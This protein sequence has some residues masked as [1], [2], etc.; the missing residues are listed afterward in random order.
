MT[1]TLMTGK[2]KS[3]SLQFPTSQQ[4]LLVGST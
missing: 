1:I 4:F 2:A 3:S